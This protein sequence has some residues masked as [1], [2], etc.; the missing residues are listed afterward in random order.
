VALAAASYPVLGRAVAGVVLA[1]LLVVGLAAHTRRRL[2]G[3]SG[4][5][6]G[7]ACELA[8]TTVLVVLAA[9]AA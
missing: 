4:D 2:G 3:M 5:V 6:L 1:A 9:S 8:T 7:A